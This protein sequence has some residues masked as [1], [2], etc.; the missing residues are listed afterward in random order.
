MRDYTKYSESNALV[1]YKKGD[2]GCEISMLFNKETKTV[3]ITVMI[4]HNTGEPTMEPMDEWE[5]HSADKGHWQ[6]EI[7]CMGMDD[8][9]F[10]HRKSLELFGQEN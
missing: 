4:F 5:K 7:T 1:C 8:I 10:L 9:K 3:D 6:M 2:N